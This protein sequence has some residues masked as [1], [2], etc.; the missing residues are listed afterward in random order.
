MCVSGKCLCGAVSY[1]VDAAPIF[2]LKC[3]CTD[4]RRTSAAVHA[5]LMGFPA[6]AVALSGEIRE[7][8]NYGDSGREV[9]RAFCPTCGA[10]IYGRNAVM[11]HF[12]FLRASSLDEPDLFDPQMIVFASRAPAWDAVP[13]GIPAFPELPPQS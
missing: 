1:Q 9:T 2:Q 6:E 10:G 5:G 11:P 12:L 13:P 7:F 8:R 4:C 3:Y